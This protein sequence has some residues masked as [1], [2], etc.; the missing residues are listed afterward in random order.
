MQHPL[1]F[2]LGPPRMVCRL[3]KSLY[4]L[5]QSPRMWFGKFTTVMCA[6]GYTQSNDDANLFFHHDPSGV[7]ILV[8]Y[9]DDILITRSDST[10]ATRLGTTLVVEFELK[11]L[12]PLRY[13]LGLEF[14]YL[15]R[16]IFVYQQKY[17]VDLLKLT[18]MVDCA[19]V[20]TPIGPNVKLG[21]GEDSPPVN[22]RQY[23]L[24]VGKLLYLTHPT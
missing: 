11:G 20:R 13:F 17:T 21:R 23:Q 19:P 18:G 5:K 3:Q 16:G 7:T 15:S 8:V 12:G 4:G 24:L 14:A 10:E 1:E 2:S 6:Q 22:H 9:V